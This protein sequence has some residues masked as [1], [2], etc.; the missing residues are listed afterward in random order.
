G[1]EPPPVL[2]YATARARLVS[3]PRGVT[4]T[5]S[6][7]QP[8]PTTGVVTL[9][10]NFPNV[11]NGSTITVAFQAVAKTVGT[12]TNVAITHSDKVPNDTEDD[13]DVP[14]GG[15]ADLTVLQKRCPPNATPGH[16]GTPF[17]DY[18]NRG[19]GAASGVTSAPTPSTTT[20]A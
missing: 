5:F 6:I 19:S 17:P 15:V 10:W 1:G 13:V 12:C 8:D 18:P 14:I 7:T 11:P 3:A 4:G 2:E 20:V 16:Q 9:S